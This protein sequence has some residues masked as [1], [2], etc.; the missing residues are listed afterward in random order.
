MYRG[1]M[2]NTSRSKTPIPSENTSRVAKL[3]MSFNQN[4][5]DY[6]FLNDETLPSHDVYLKGQARE[7][8]LTNRDSTIL[9]RTLGPSVIQYFLLLPV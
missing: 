2:Y 5:W 4:K 9:Q 7:R 6:T 1:T 8:Y 3:N